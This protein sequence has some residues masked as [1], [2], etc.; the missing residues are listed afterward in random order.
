MCVTRRAHMQCKHI[1]NII[2]SS[3]AIRQEIRKHG[4][5]TPAAAAAALPIAT[6]NNNINNTVTLTDAYGHE[7]N[8]ASVLNFIFKP[9][10]SESTAATTLHFFLTLTL[11]F[12]FFLY[13][14]SVR[15][16]GYYF[17]SSIHTI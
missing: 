12:A 3:R 10:S 16:C 8:R 6:I 14:H 1:M 7:L 13:A 2:H 9:K 11:S 4:I 17:K 15:A 5:T